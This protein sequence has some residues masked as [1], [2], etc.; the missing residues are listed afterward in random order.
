VN[1]FV[2][3]D[4]AMVRRKT[5]GF[6]MLELIIV[7]AIIMIVAGITVEVVQK[8]AQ[9]MRLQ[10]SAITYSGLLQQ[11]RIRAIQNDKYYTVLTSTGGTTA[12]TAFIDLAGTGV[13]A[14]GDPMMVFP[15]G[16]SP[17]AFSSGPSL[18]NLEAQFLPPDPASLLTLNTTALGPSFGPRGLPCTPSSAGPTGTCPY[19]TPAGIP[20]S[21]LTFL[22]NGESGK[23]EAV[24]ITPAGRI[25]QWAY[26]S[27]TWSSLN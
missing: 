15:S 27:G 11:A 19:L 3:L 24:T 13:Y 21:Y 18:A 17:M 10:E 16:V 26:D 25:R 8:A 6:S 9:S 1:N 7:I 12:P 20:T 2:D 14:P 22:E 4:K 5:S 23:W